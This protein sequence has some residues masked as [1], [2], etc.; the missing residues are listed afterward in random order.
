MLWLG[1]GL[2]VA[3][4]GGVAGRVLGARRPDAR[5]AQPPHRYGWQIRP[6]LCSKCGRCETACVRRP[7]AVKACND[8]RACYNCVVCYGHLLDR[9]TP[10]DRIPSEGRRI[11]PYDAVRRAPFKDGSSNAFVYTIDPD[12]CVACGRIAWTWLGIALLAGRLVPRVF[13][14]YV[15]PYGVLLG[16]FS[17][18]AFRRRRIDPDLCR[19][20]ETCQEECPVQAIRIDRASREARL[21]VYQCIQCG[22][23]S[24]LCKPGTVE[25]GHAH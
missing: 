16:L 11:C 25:A 5:Q 20:C 17:V 18:F 7:S 12:R 10:A 9:H 22:R 19:H 1:R 15:C 23:C 13:C 3:A 21:S 14:R 2:G 8:Q 4:L 6:D 24:R